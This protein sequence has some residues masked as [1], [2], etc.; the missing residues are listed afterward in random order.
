MKKRLQENIAKKESTIIESFNRVCKQLG[1]LLE[2]DH[3]DKH[4]KFLLYRQPSN[5]PS[6]GHGEYLF[7]SGN[8]LEELFQ[9][10]I[11]T[12]KR[13]GYSISSDW[14]AKEK[15][16]FEADKENYFVTGRPRMFYRFEVNEGFDTMYPS[17]D[18]YFD[19]VIK[20]LYDLDSGD[21]LISAVE[22]GHRSGAHIRQNYEKKISPE[23][24]ADFIR[25]AWYGV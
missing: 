19:A 18:S 17:L 14:I 5:S 13:G 11:Y 24:T 20:G 25:G 7:S 12:M 10:W 16:A 3:R 23:K 2:Q 21:K 4:D 9:N 22:G 1:I 8:S 6:P 15:A